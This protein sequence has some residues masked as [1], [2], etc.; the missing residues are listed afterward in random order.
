LKSLGAH[1]LILSLED[2]TV[3]DLTSALT[4]HNPDIVVFAAGAGGKGD[5]SRT[6]AVDYEGAVK[7]YDAMESANVRR[8]ILVGAVDI[9]D[10]DREVPGWYDDEDGAYISACHLRAQWRRRCDA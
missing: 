2:S 10:R 7:V 4:A 3:P 6:R 5:K 9:R 1:P 8:L